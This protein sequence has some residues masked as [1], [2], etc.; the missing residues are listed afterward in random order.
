[1]DK[2]TKIQLDNSQEITIMQ[3]K[4]LEFQEDVLKTAA[5]LRVFIYS[6]LII[7]PTLLIIGLLLIY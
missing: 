5:L 7:I 3:L 6:W 2:D 1:M 4:E